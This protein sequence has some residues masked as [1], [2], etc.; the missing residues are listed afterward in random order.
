MLF[1]NLRYKG[2]DLDYYFEYKYEY[3]NIE[4]SS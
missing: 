4:I 1:L 2:C 3:K